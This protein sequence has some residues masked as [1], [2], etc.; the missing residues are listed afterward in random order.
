M[1]K[2][3]ILLW[4]FLLPTSWV[5]PQA[6]FFIPNGSK[7][8]EIP[9]EYINNFI[10][11]NLSINNTLPLK[12]IFD[13]G[14]EHTILTKREIS[15]VLRI[16]YERE[17]KITGSDLNTEL[18]AYLARKIRLDI[19]DKASAPSEDIL[20]LQEDYFRFDEFA[21]ISVH[22]I[23]SGNV[24]SKF[25]IKINYQRQIITLYDRKSYK[26]REN[27]FESLPVEIFR[28]KI[29]LKTRLEILHDSIA[30]VKLL[31]DTGA[32]LPML[33]FSNTNALLHP[34]PEAISSKIAMGLGGFLEGYVG[35]IR[36]IDLGTKNQH[37]IVTYFQR[38]DTSKNLEYLN[39]RNGL[40]GNVLLSRFL[41][42]IDYQDSKIWLK[43]S[44]NFKDVFLFDRSGMNVIISGPA[45]NI[46]TVQYVGG[47]TPAWDADI[48]PGDQV[49]RIGMIPTAF[50][51]LAEVQK[52]LQRRPGKTVQLLIKRDGKRIRKKI[53][54]RELI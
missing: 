18:V 30:S 16:R 39:H 36:K 35:R 8:V 40:I 45:L 10:I 29:Y 49:L 6:G 4:L 3:K 9:F 21:G 24:F 44:S 23:L 48:R 28:N 2:T 1:V 43:P 13:T 26:M 14:A 33:L 27:G 15:D 19:G 52:R 41:V 25:I 5:L 46:F 31:L 11:L 51:S 53:V 20:V 12:F 54:L 32:G 42:I 47:R 22:G 17:F 7:S 38:Q 34:P 50:L 37:N